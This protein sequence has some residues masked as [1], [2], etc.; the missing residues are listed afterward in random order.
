MVRRLSGPTP[1][2][3]TDTDLGRALEAMTAPELRAFVRAVL[4][5]FEDE[6]RSRVINSLLSRA[7]N[8]EPAGSRIVRRP[9]S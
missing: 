5:E 7:P 3:S 9:E 4:A 8:G 6:Q 1:V 2:R